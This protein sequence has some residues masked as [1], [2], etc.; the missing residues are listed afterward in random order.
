[1]DMMVIQE[2]YDNNYITYGLLA[3]AAYGILIK[4]IVALIY[5]GL[6][7]A[8]DTMGT[9]GNKLM[10]LLRMKFETCYKLKI[11]VKNVD[12]FVDK[13][14]YKYRFMGILLYT[15][16]SIGGQV[17]I[18]S[19]LAG[20]VAVVTAIAGQCGQV[21]MLSTLL[22]SICA[23]AL[24]VT[25]E[26]MLNLPMKRKV[27]RVNI[28]DYLDNF[29]KARLEN[30]YLHPE[31]LDAYCKAY[32][33]ERADEVKEGKPSGEEQGD[34]VLVEPIS[35]VATAL[36]E[37]AADGTEVDE[38]LVELMNSILDGEVPEQKADKN[39]APKEMAKK[40][41]STDEQAEIVTQAYDLELER[42]RRQRQENEKLIHAIDNAIA[43]RSKQLQRENVSEK[44]SRKKHS[45]EEKI[46]EEVLKEYL[47]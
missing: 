12:S 41:Q 23:C 27:L 1:M 37:S 31:E 47:G 10:K 33:T 30:E 2:W 18:I 43:N 36:D 5:K 39:E 20:T 42:L 24:L 6:L 34:S 15:W 14:I 45:Q 17:L 9:S 19:M 7:K 21:A 3:I 32:F 11:G 29:L 13:Y 4:C 38:G 40:E 26:S 46:I 22:A 16:E 28:I 25:A 8:S 44:E 35:E